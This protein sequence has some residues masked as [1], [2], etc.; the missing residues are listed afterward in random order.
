MSLS[1]SMHELAKVL[2]SMPADLTVEVNVTN[3]IN[4][5]IPP[6]FVEY[7]TDSND[8]TAYRRVIETK[9]GIVTKSII[10][11]NRD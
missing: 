3:H 8:A 9:D 1:D 4:E 11:W 2:T 6:L 7:I 5:A 10:F